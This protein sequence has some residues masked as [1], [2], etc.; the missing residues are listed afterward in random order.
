MNE[1]YIIFYTC[2]VLTTACP[3]NK[4]G[5]CVCHPPYEVEQSGQK[6]FEYKKDLEDFIKSK[7]M[8]F[9]LTY[10]IDSKYMEKLSGAIIY[11]KR[12]KPNE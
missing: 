8:K 1:L 12:S 6:I 2:F 10:K 4:P 11:E 3:D 7:K 5:C 9:Y